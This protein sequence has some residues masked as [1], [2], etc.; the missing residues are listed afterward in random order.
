MRFVLILLSLLIA[1]LP[2]NAADDVLKRVTDGFILPHYHDF[3]IKNDAQ[4]KAWTSFCTKPDDAGFDAVRAAYLASADAWSAIEIIRY[5][6]VA[7][8]YRIERISHWPERKNAVTKALSSLLAGEGTADLSPELFVK[9]SVAGQGFPALERLLFDGDDPKSLFF[10]SSAA[11]QRRCAVGTA[12]AANLARIG[13]EIEAGWPAIVA[14]FGNEE[15]ATE[16]KTRLATDYIAHFVFIRDAKL[17]A[18][19]GK[20]P[21]LA[22]PLL[23][24]GWRSK[25]TKQALLI[26]LDSAKAMATIILQGFDA[27]TPSMIDTARSLT[28]EL[29]SDFGALA[30]QPKTRPGLFLV[31]DAVTAVRDKASD[32]IP[33]ALGVTVGFNS[34]DGD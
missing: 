27:Y 17:R 13:H 8:N 28:E 12:I 15:F 18:V 19:F 16:V 4:E 25:R 21:A 5:G 20:E 30:Q 31:L 3:T 2:A 10:A 29:D 24:E 6:P 26:N 1:T 9:N 11:A 34:L 14:Q 23:A 7:E 22:R 32:E 33:A